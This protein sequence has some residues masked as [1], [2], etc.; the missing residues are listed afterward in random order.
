MLANLRTYDI[1]QGP[2][3]SEEEEE[4][5]EEDRFSLQGTLITARLVEL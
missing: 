4:E 1:H 2:E 3:K 5:E